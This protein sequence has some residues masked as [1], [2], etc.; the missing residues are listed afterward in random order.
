MRSKQV[1]YQSSSACSNIV[2]R[3]PNVIIINYEMLSDK[4]VLKNTL[5]I[6][7]TACKMPVIKI[8]NKVILWDDNYTPF[9]CSSQ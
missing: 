6:W 7:K 3:Y 8:Q 4:Q 1:Y 2:T 9:Q 5:K